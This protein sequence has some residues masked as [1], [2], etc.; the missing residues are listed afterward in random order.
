MDEQK[1]KDVS[2]SRGDLGDSTVTVS[3]HVDGKSETPFE[4]TVPESQVGK[5]EGSNEAGGEEDVMVEVLG[6]HVVVDGVC[7]SSNGARV[8]GEEHLNDEQ[9]CGLGGGGSA[10]A[11]VEK[12]LRSVSY[13]RDVVSD[14]GARESAVSGVEV[15]SSHRL[16]ARF[17]GSLAEERAAVGSLERNKE[18][19]GSEGEG[20]IVDEMCAHE[21]GAQDDEVQD[22]GMG[23]KVEG[24]TTD[25]GS[26]GRETQVVQAEDIGVVSTEEGLE[27]G[28]PKEDAERGSEM[29]SGVVCEAQ[30]HGVE[31]VVGSSTVESGTLNEETQV[32][33]KKA[34][35]ENENVVDKDLVQGAEQGGEIYAAAGGDAQ[36]DVEP[37]NLHTSNDK[38]LNPCS[39]V[40]VA[41][42]PVTV[43]YLSVPIQVVEKAAVTVNDKGL[44]P[45]IDAAGIDSTEGIISSS[46]EKK[47]PIAM[48][49][50]RGRGKDSIISAHSKSMDY[51]NPVAVTREVAEMDKEEFMC[52]TMEDSLSFYH[53]TQVVGSEDAMMDK[54]VHPSENHQQSK[55]QGCLDQGT[56]HYVA[57]VNSNTQEPMEIHEQVSTAELDEMLSCS[58][59][60]QNF[61]DGRL[62]MDTAL[63][64]QVTTRGD[65]IPLI[66][67]QEAL[68]SNTKVQMPTEN[69]QQLKLQ[70]RF[71]NT[72][73]CHLAQ[74]QVD[75]GKEMEIQ[76]QVAGGKFTAVD[77]KVSSNPIV[78]VPCPSVQVINEGEGLQTAEGDMSAAGSLS[79][80]DSTVEGEMHVEE[81]V[82]DAEQAALQGDQEMEVE[83]QDSDT[84][85]TETNEEKFVHRVTARGGSLVKPHRVSCLLPLED[86]GEFFVSD[87]VWGKVRS[88]PWW[89]GQIYHPSD[90]SEKAMKYH[91]KDCFL[92]AY[93]GDRTFA[94]VD[95]SQLRPFYSHF[96]QVEKQSNAE[97]FQNAV[98]CA[99]E[100]VSRRIELGLACPCI[101]KD[102]YDKIR[103]QI[104]ENAGIRQES[105]ER[106]GVDKCASAQS[107]QPDKLV[108]FM[109]AFAL[110]PSG[111]ADRLEL[112]IAKS[113]LL[114]FY[115]FKGYSELPEFQ[116]CGGLA[117]DGVDTSHFAEKMHTTPVS[118]DDEHIYSET[119]RSS[120]H[121]R[122]HNLKDSMYPSKKEKSLSEL[123]TGSFDS[124]D[125]D[126]FDSDGKA[127]GKLVSPSS[128][129]K[130]KVID[131]AGDDSSQD[132]RKTISLAK[133]SISMANIPKPSFKIGECIRRVASQMTGS[134]SVLKSNSERLQK[135]DA[136]GS[137]DS[138][139]NFE[140]AEGKR[141]ILPTDY[142]SLDD[143]LSQLHSAAKDPMRG[144]SFLNMII[145]FFSD[146]RNSIISD[147]RAIDKVGGKR[148]K[149]S[150]IMGSP[151]TFEFEDMSDTYWTDRVIQNGAEEQPSAPA[152]PAGPAATSGNTQRYQV[153]PVE[154]KPVQKSRRSYSRKQYSDANHDLT[155]PK[156]P[157]YVDENAPAELIIN[158]SEMDTIPSE[159]NLSKMF[160]CFGPLK[161]SETEVDRESSRA[162]VV[163]KKCSD[164]EVA[165]SSA[166]KFNIF[167]PKVVNYQLS[168]TISE[169]FKA[170]PI[171]ASLG[172]DYAT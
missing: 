125:D 32:V 171:G 4:S 68:N 110:S 22:R 153:V 172:E 76:K 90:A 55:L 88:H 136:D 72:G 169:Q 3:E 114:S 124:L 52:S 150:Q 130:R 115:R 122:K 15:S 106:E 19:L 154:L 28:L 123:M 162:R 104:V 9:I 113:Q 11:G 146:F 73:V 108:E 142:S 89:P 66:N 50:C 24:S 105:S 93:F 63:D 134:S 45:K 159:T 2:V 164:A 121:K 59:D 17:E 131:F 8:G 116:F 48:T 149:S 144:N 97:V 12:D 156:P 10:E 99:L 69:D 148:K 160:R 126:E 112:V 56:A 98:N 87:L 83:G 42:S 39:R 62:A 170:L 38:T 81:Q 101:P 41:G 82:T 58:G 137:D 102:A 36:Q 133:V 141:M 84:E 155:P 95:A 49:D 65:E 77:E 118:M 14:L 128:I 33:K 1:D 13:A 29:V 135:L 129:K 140:D 92:V 109:K 71:D 67:N 111:G 61:K 75:V 51:Q 96:S 31:N 26:T 151:E 80:V 54:N 70:E 18:V 40:A 20:C 23:T 34:D 103:L 46:E 94:W 53:P 7:S 43:E 147:R 47:I 6:S 167:G 119:Q 117:E 107:F 44:K 5:I 64:T 37:Q 35:K 132:G 85:Q 163:F 157:G 143:L 27:R 78:E 152:A 139:E 21:N 79:G 74:P 60:V 161:E 166:T 16:E 168:Y 30:G 127:G 57:Q 165:H 145:S 86:E 138:F 158:F 91:K 120:L 25:V 100:E